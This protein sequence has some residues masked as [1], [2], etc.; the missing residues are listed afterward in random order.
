M[1]AL[2]C[3][4]TSQEGQV[5]G[6]EQQRG[7][8]GRE[9]GGGQELEVDG[10][11]L[12]ELPP[13]LKGAAQVGGWMGSQEGGGKQQLRGGVSMLRR[14]SRMQGGVPAGRWRARRRRGCGGWGR[15]GA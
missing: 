14:G 13:K 11:L 12:L 3:V 2:R 1:H 10:P 5:E 9:H 8:A 15:R 4:R 7:V 6:E